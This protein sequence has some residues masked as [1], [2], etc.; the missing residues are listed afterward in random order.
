MLRYE[1]ETLRRF[2]IF[3]HRPDQ[4]R[5]SPR[6]FKLFLHPTD[7]APRPAIGHSLQVQLFSL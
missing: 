7:I 6:N 5:I 3:G 2:R 4:N 1:N